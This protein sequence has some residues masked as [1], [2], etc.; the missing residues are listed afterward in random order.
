MFSP[1][2]VGLAPEPNNR[3]SV[4]DG[5]AV[6]LPVGSACHWNIWLTALLVP[7][8]NDDASRLKGPELDPALAVAVPRLGNCTWPRTTALPF[9]SSVAAGVVLLI[10]I[11]AVAPEP[12]WKITELTM[13]DVVSHSG[14]KF[15][16]PVPV[17][18]L[19]TSGA[20]ASV[21]TAAVSVLAAAPAVGAARTKAEGGNP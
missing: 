6:S 8:L 3:F 19:D 15:T 21:L 17:T 10:P 11:L 14:T 18:G 4:P 2:S 1:V 16:V 9:T 20:N 7:L 13:S 12:D 5:V